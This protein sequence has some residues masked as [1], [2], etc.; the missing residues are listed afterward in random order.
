MKIVLITDD[1][2]IE[3]LDRVLDG[4]KKQKKPVYNA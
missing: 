2:K 1:S 3:F 4:I